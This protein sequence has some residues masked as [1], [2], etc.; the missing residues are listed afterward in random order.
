MIM[1]N[2]HTCWVILQDTSSFVYKDA[3][4]TGWLILDDTEILNI[5]YEESSKLLGILR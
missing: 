1:L 3:M 5:S 2:K 4:I